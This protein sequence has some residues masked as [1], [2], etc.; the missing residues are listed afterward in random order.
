ML[1]SKI[2]TMMSSCKYIKRFVYKLAK[3]RLDVKIFCYISQ[4]IL[5]KILLYCNVVLKVVTN[6]GSK[7]PLEL[8]CNGVMANNVAGPLQNVKCEVEIFFTALGF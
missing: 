5:W 6:F 4:G 3:T 8:F 7:S 2:E 1:L